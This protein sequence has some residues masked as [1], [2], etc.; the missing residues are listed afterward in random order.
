MSALII[1]L[2]H[3]RKH[4]NI[5][6]HSFQVCLFIND[7]AADISIDTTIVTM[8]IFLISAYLSCKTMHK[9]HMPDTNFSNLWYSRMVSSWVPCVGC[10]FMTALERIFLWPLESDPH[11]QCWRRFLNRQ[12][13]FYGL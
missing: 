3:K 10:L 5:K 12:Q 1:V 2:S 13:F 6:K 7:T 8:T 4:I 9:N 11:Y